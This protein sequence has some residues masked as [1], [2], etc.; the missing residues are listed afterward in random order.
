MLSCGPAFYLSAALSDATSRQAG[1]GPIWQDGRPL[2]RV[3]WEEVPA[4][5][6]RAV[7]QAEMCME[8]TEDTE[9]GDNDYC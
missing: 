1:R 8:C 2:C 9:D 6:V 4:E 7:P 5:R 3:C